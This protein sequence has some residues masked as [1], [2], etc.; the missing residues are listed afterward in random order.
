MHKCQSWPRSLFSFG[1]RRSSGSPRSRPEVRPL[2]VLPGTLPPGA[3]DVTTEALLRLRRTD[4]ARP[5]GFGSGPRKDGLAAL[6]PG[7][8]RTCSRARALKSLVAVWPWLGQALVAGQ[9]PVR[10]GVARRVAACC[11]PMRSSMGPGARGNRRSPLCSGG[12]GR[13][14]GFRAFRAL[15]FA[16]DPPM[17]GPPAADPLASV[18]ERPYPAWDFGRLVIGLGHVAWWPALNVNDQ[19]G[20]DTY[21]P[22]CSQMVAIGG[23]R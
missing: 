1:S 3:R 20:A 11:R 6:E 10:L 13:I 14:R 2:E 17:A 19:E 8:A 9:R 18:S 15:V 7:S 21:S 12:G 23:A 22:G 16:R 5:C 4:Q